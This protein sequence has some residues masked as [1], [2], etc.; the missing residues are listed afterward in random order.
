MTGLQSATLWMAL[1]LQSAPEAALASATPYLRL[2]SLTA[3]GAL[4]RQGCACRGERLAARRD[5]TL[6]RGKPADRGNRPRRGRA[7]RG[8][9][10]SRRCARRGVRMSAEV[11]VSRADGAQVLRLTRPEKKNALTGAMYSAL[12]DAIEAATATARSPRMSSSVR[13][14]SS[15]LVTISAIFLRPRAG[16][17]SLRSTC[18][19]SSA[20][21]PSFK[22]R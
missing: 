14:A 7:K 19:A 10:G 17:E 5:R 15:R 12:S 22:S 1:M 21:C 11:E 4:P 18:C 20:C 3:G 8:R 6:F 13:A 2:M 16:P 9:F